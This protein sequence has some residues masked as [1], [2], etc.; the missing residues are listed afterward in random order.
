MILMIFRQGIDLPPHFPLQIEPLRYLPRLRSKLRN[1][2]REA[3]VL[4]FKHIQP[5]KKCLG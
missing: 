3:P 1:L 2:T 5:S 4:E